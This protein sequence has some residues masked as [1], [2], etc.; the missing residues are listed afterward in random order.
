MPFQPFTIDAS[1]TR[2]GGGNVY[3]HEGY[4]LLRVVNN[5]LSAPD[6]RSDWSFITWN[7]KIEDGLEQ[8][9][10]T[11]NHTTTTKPDSHWALGGLI[12]AVGQ[13]P[14]AIL[15]IQIQTYQQL[16]QITQQL[17]GVAKDKTMVA[18]IADGQPGPQG[19]RNSDIK[20]L[21]PA[22]EWE[23]LKVNNARFAAAMAANPQP[24]M[25]PAMMPNLLPQSPF[26]A[27]PQAAAP[28]PTVTPELQGQVA[29]IFSPQPTL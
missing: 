2:I 7:L 14:N 5:A 23:S 26:A 22:S 9:G 10:R 13:D 25:A 18:L 19:Q 4:Y 21:F 20:A 8:V 3:V 11:F 24:A 6:H 27:P 17:L 12:N 28:A 1:V 16:Q 15:G 29:N